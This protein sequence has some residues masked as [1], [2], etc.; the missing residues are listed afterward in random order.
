VAH[1]N[2]VPIR[3]YSVV[4]VVAPELAARMEDY[5]SRLAAINSGYPVLTDWHP[6]IPQGWGE[7]P[8]LPVRRATVYR[9][10]EETGA[11][12]HHQGIAKLGDR[13][14]VAWSNGFR[15]EDYVGQRVCCAWSADGT[16]WSA[17]QVIAHTPVES[18]LVR[19]NAG[20]YSTGGRLYCY[21]GVAKDFGRDVSPPGM[22]V[23]LEQQVRLDVYETTDL[24]NWTHHEGVC[25]NVYLFEGPR[26][27]GGGKLLCCGFELS[28][29]H[30][31]ALIWD[32][33]ARPSAHPRVV[34]IPP[35]AE[36]VLPE[37]GTWYQTDDGRIWMYMRD[38]SIS[39]RL[40]LTWSEDEG[41]TWSDLLRTNFPNTYSRAFAGRFS[42]GRYYI[43]GNNFDRL[44][45]RRALLIA[46]SDDGRVFDRQYTLVQ[47]DTTRRINGRHKEDGY[48][49]PNCCVDGDRLLVVYSVNKEDIEVISVGAGEIE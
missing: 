5:R 32:D 46:L 31:E 33:P 49:Y 23:L 29:H 41:E 1:R 44:L 45:D 18:K 34:D 15:H 4:N 43:V 20:L 14:V 27:T 40:A 10:C 38:S 48:H 11:Y 36:G 9:G 28:G 35:S 16:D 8:R 42:D 25:D 7:F 17:P 37:Q 24:E 26:K 30:G 39:C 6:V 19:N 21:V 47:G 13:Y 12:N 2:A 3:K 22:T